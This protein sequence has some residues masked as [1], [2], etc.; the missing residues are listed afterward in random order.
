MTTLNF[1]EVPGLKRDK[2]NGN[3]A[4]FTLVGGLLLSWVT[5]FLYENLKFQGA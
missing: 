1:L 4:W 2:N 5:I 3:R